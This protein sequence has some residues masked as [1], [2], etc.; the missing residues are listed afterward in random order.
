M[1]CGAFTLSHDEKAFDAQITHHDY[2]LKLLK[3]LD[4]LCSNTSLTSLAVVRL[5]LLGRGAF[6]LSHDHTLLMLKSHI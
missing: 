2:K 6:A 3:P 5:Y 4:L 1:S